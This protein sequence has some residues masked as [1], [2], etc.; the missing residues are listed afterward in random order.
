M[1]GDKLINKQY[2]KYLNN[3]NMFWKNK[4]KENDSEIKVIQIGV[5]GFI[6]TGKTLLIDAMLSL[7]VDDLSPHY[8]PIK[9]KGKLN[10]KWNKLRYTDYDGL[11]DLVRRK[12]DQSDLKTSAENGIW[13]LNT[14][15][16]ILDFCGKKIKLIIRNIPGEIFRWYF[17]NANANINSLNR[18]FMGFCPKDGYENLFKE[19]NAKEIAGI[20]VDDKDGQGNPVKKWK[21][22]IRDAFFDHIKKEKS[23][24]EYDNFFAYLFF[25]SSDFNIYCRSSIEMNEIEAEM[26]KE[27]DEKETCRNAANDYILSRNRQGGKFILAITKFDRI[28]NRERFFNMDNRS[29]NNEK[30]RNIMSWIRD[31]II[32][33]I[34]ND[35]HANERNNGS[36]LLDLYWTRM[37]NLYRDALLNIEQ[38]EIINDKKNWKYLLEQI[39][40]EN[41][42]GSRREPY[43]FFLTSTAY[44]NS[45]DKFFDYTKEGECRWESMNIMRRSSMGVLEMMLHILH[46]SGF[47]LKES[48]IPFDKHRTIANKILKKFDDQP[49]K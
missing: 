19:Y 22:G 45:A 47:K 5:G 4:K 48:N 30:E 12:I 32:S 23:G 40:I 16:G 26:E 49:T 7:F 21:G 44:H 1:N 46:N 33:Q 28:I 15:E 31:N 29:S 10:S 17:A 14:Y 34:N 36:D 37:Q 24:V 3:R 38:Q 20:E 39:G 35:E 9:F 8:L 27:R 25:I 41:L 42:N 11:L 43:S 2:V 18:Q 13:D 6:S